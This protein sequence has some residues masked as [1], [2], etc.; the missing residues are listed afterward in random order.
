MIPTAKGQS[1]E[2]IDISANVYSAR[3]LLIH[4]LCLE[5]MSEYRQGFIRTNF[6]AHLDQESTSEK[7]VILFNLILR[8]RLKTN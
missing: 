3:S 4:T 1:P 7:K 8:H 2:S 6:L 5:V